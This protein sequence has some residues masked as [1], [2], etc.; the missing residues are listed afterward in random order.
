MSYPRRFGFGLIATVFFALTMAS[1]AVSA[2]DASLE[3][4]FREPPAEARPYVWWHWMGANISREG[5][6]KDLEAMKAA[7]IGGATVFNLSSGVRESQAPIGD[8]PWPER[9]YRSEEYWA[10]L[11]HA[12]AEARRLGLELGL[13][14]TVGYSTTG[15]PWVSEA[16]SMK[17]VVWSETA[18][19]GGAPVDL[20]LPRPK[21]DLNGG[22]GGIHREPSGFYRDIAV[23]AVPRGDGPIA[24]DALIDVSSRMGPDGRLNWS[25]APAGDWSVVRLG[26]GPTGSTPH[27]VPDELI[28]GVREVDKLDAEANREHWQAVLAPLR[29][30]LGIWSAPGCVTC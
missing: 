5:I 17:K 13:H 6:T 12:A 15:G 21:A 24:R 29:E 14:N 16:R 26:Y 23:I 8:L 9:T 19:V 3:S 1:P 11:R 25:D 27:P 30:K 18:V 22:W 4:R 7:G 28:G 10:C 2:A 20:V